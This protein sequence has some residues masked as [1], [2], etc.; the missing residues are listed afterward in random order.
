LTRHDPAGSPK[1]L[2]RL[3]PRTEPKSCAHQ[4]MTSTV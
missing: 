2:N 1:F 4:T 3:G